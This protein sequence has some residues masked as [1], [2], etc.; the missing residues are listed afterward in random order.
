MTVDP[1]FDW[2]VEKAERASVI[3]AF[4]PELA[5]RLDRSVSDIEASGLSV[6]DFQK[7]GTVKVTW[8]DD[9]EARFEYAFALASADGQR[10]GLFTEHC[11][12]FVLQ[13]ARIESVVEVRQHLI[14]SHP[15]HE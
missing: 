10:I 4:L 14:F 1:K 7:G 9:S 6:H 2:Q 8:E 11:G 5:S 12:Y 13:A 3:A 15:G